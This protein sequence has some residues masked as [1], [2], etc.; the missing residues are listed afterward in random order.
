MGGFSQ[1]V[2]APCV[3]YMTKNEGDQHLWGLYQ[4]GMQG[5]LGPR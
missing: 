4:E 5:K 2:D 3:V 1:V